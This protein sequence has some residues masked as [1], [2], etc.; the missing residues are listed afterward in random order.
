[1]LN[2]ID[3]PSQIVCHA[4]GRD[5]CKIQAITAMVRKVLR[6]PV[7]VL[8]KNILFAVGSLMTDAD[9]LAFIDSLESG[10]TPNAD[11][12][13][14]DGNKNRKKKKKKKKKLSQSMAK[15]VRPDFVGAFSS[16]RSALT[17]NPSNTG[18]LCGCKKSF[19]S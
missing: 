6:V 15:R 2:M 11:A 4:F 5:F 10:G 16:F 7:L 18:P 8:V 13:T 3:L 17:L 19:A 9:A 12:P 1:M 14:N